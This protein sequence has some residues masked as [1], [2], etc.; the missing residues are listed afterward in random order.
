MPSV[1]D[2]RNTSYGEYNK[3]GQS[4]GLSG[5]GSHPRGNNE[6]SDKKSA[7]SS[8]TIGSPKKDGLGYKRSLVICLESFQGLLVKNQEKLEALCVRKDGG[9]GGSQI[10]RINN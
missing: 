8:K 10:R 4:S 9:N 1:P 5:H 2:Y 7:T 6:N 3:Y